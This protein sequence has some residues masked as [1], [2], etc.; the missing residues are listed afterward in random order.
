MMVNQISFEEKIEL[1][2]T[3]PEGKARLALSIIEHLIRPDTETFDRNKALELASMVPYASNE[4]PDDSDWD[5][6]VIVGM[7]ALSQSASMLAIVP[8]DPDN[9]LEIRDERIDSYVLRF[10]GKRVVERLDYQLTKWDS[11]K[12]PE[13]G[14]VHKLAVKGVYRFKTPA[15]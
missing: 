5:E 13:D 1:A 10:S 7:W 3:M 12:N 8:L 9:S 4:Y 6:R 11:V 2:M 14:T 15:P